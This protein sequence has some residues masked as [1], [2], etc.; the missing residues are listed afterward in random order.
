MLGV[1]WTGGRTHG[2][3]DMR[4]KRVTLSGMG[5]LFGAYLKETRVA[6]RLTLRE[7]G[8]ASGVSH[9][10]VQY[11]EAGKRI[12][13]SDRMATLC[14]AVPACDV[15]RARALWLQDQRNALAAGVAEAMARF[16]GA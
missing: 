9:A 13:S 12:P 7:V 4:P 5:T 10:F 2:K 14:A 3:V 15:E 8:A 6:S 11:V 16:G 1:S